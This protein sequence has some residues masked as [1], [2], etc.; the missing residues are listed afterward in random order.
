MQASLL[1]A[2]GALRPIESRPHLLAGDAVL[3]RPYSPLG[4]V[5][6]R[7]RDLPGKNPLVP[8]P[9]MSV[10]RSAIPGATVVLR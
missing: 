8:Q 4:E 10:A 1:L 3:F 7:L 6:A 9:N 2:L 5:I